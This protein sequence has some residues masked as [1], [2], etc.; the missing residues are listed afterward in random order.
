[1]ETCQPFPH[2]SQVAFWRDHQRLGLEIDS[3]T[4]GNNLGKPNGILSES[5]FSLLVIMGNSL[6]GWVVKGVGGTRAGWGYL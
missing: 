5:A 4:P 2:F 1:M 6:R 3:D